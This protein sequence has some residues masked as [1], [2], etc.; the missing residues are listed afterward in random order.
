[1]TGLSMEVAT[2]S[3]L[4]RSNGISNKNAIVVKDVTYPT[5]ILEK[6]EKIVPLHNDKFNEYLLMHAMLSKL[7]RQNRIFNYQF[8]DTDCAQN[9]TCTFP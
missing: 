3:D 7:S 8:R 9:N 6:G 1:M 5:C 4:I 2:E